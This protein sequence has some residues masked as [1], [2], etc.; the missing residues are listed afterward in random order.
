MTYTPGPG[1]PSPDEGVASPDYTLDAIAASFT[2]LKGVTAAGQTLGTVIKTVKNIID[3]G[4]PASERTVDVT[5]EPATNPFDIVKSDSTKNFLVELKKRVLDSDL[6]QIYKIVKK[7]ELILDT[8]AGGNRTPSEDEIKKALDAQE[9]RNQELYDEETKGNKLIRDGMQLE[10][11]LEPDKTVSD[12]IED[13]SLADK[14]KVVRR[15]FYNKRK[16]DTVGRLYDLR[17][18]FSLERL[19]QQYPGAKNADFRREIQTLAAD[20][21]FSKRD[22]K[23]GGKALI[24]DWLDGLDGVADDVKLEIHHVRTVRYV[25]ALFDKLNVNERAVLLN[26]LLENMFPVGDNPANLMPLETKVHDQLHARLNEEIGMYAEKFIDKN[27]NYTIAE[28]VAIAKRM[29]KIINRLTDEAYDAMAVVMEEKYAEASPQAKT[30]ATSRITV[31]EANE[32]LDF[33]FEQMQEQNIRGFES[34]TRRMQT[35]DEVT[36]EPLPYKFEDDSPSEKLRQERLLRKKKP[37]NPDQLELNIRL[38]G[39]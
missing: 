15:A 38:D 13:P 11:D 28:R 1:E 25:G 6:G 12:L 4:R 18:R 7:G 22:F 14:F 23:Q 32:A 16:P 29:G 35:I 9:Q 20:P 10:L 30:D 36:G 8:T 2:P 24:E 17:G 3:K 33:I 34:I 21:R 37:K 19:R 39:Q 26:Q 5:A 31:Q 27:A